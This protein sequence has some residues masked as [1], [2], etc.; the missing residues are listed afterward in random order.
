MGAAPETVSIIAKHYLASQR[1]RAL[2]PHK[3]KYHQ[4]AIE[5][6]AA[7]NGTK[8]LATMRPEHLERLLAKQEALTD[9]SAANRWL[10]AIQALY[11]FAAHWEMRRCDF[12]ILY[13]APLRT[14]SSAIESVPNAVEPPELPLKLYA[15]RVASTGLFKFWISKRPETRLQDLQVGSPMRLAILSR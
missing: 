3:R 11:R 4:W 14:H 2:S 12:R 13:L 6:F 10:K 7:A 1:F 5:G 8:C 15:M 9:T